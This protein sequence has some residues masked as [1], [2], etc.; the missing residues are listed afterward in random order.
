MER[1]AETTKQTYEGWDEFYSK[2]VDEKIEFFKM[3]GRVFDII[4]AQQFDRHLLDLLCDL[5]EKIRMLAKTKMGAQKLSSL[6]QHKRAMLYFV[7]PSTR[8]FC[9]SRMPAIS[10]G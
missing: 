7:Q 8:T 3:K 9:R 1:Y 2:P 10:W 5:A 6:L 4:Y